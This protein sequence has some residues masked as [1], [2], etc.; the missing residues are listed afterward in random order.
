MNTCETAL[1]TPQS[2]KQQ[3]Q[4]TYEEAIDIISKLEQVIR[5]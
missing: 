2:G 1:Y 3:M 5:K 4:H